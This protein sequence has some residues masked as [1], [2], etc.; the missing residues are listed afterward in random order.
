MS[1]DI[2]YTVLTAWFPFGPTWAP[3]LA[4]T[5]PSKDEALEAF[6]RLRPSRF[7]PTYVLVGLSG[8]DDGRYTAQGKYSVLSFEPLSFK[9]GSWHAGTD[10]GA[11]SVTLQYWG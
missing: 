1:T 8:S 10:Q 4:I 11:K 6:V 7:S 2:R 3:A 9:H 5:F